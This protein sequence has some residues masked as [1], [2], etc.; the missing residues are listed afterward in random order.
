[1][2]EEQMLVD[3]NEN[4]KLDDDD[5]SGGE[6]GEGNMMANGIGRRGHINTTTAKRSAT[7]RA[8]AFGSV[9]GSEKEESLDS[10]FDIEG[11]DAS[12]LGDSD[13][14]DMELMNLATG[15]DDGKAAEGG[16][17]KP[18]QSQKQERDASSD[19]DF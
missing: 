13:L 8:R 18:A 10:D 5:V 6:D 12:D 2:K 1:M 3:G 19:D 16:S 9:L 4:G 17:A 7:G 14:D 15:D 11:E